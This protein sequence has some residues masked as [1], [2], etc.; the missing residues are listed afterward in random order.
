MGTNTTILAIGDSN[1]Y[2]AGV[3][4]NEA[5]PAQ[6]EKKLTNN[7]Y[8]CKV[9]N[10]GI[11]GNTSKD[12]A[13]R[14]GEALAEYQPDIVI[15]LFGVADLRRGSSIED[16]YHNLSEMIERARGAG[17]QVIIVGY[18]GYPADA[19]LEEKLQ[20]I[21]Q[22]GG[23]T[24]KNDFFEMYARLSRDYQTDLIPNFLEGVLGAE[25]TLQ[26][27][28]FSHLTGKGYAIFVEQLYPVVVRNIR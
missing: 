12:G 27:D 17:A 28:Q 3:E 16:I 26:D 6:L 7:G 1:T 10:K 25:G 5:Y 4:R 24:L 19:G 20:N 8:S 15:L 23:V 11:N 2:G 9:M 21:A 18:Q 13:A 14:L 22:K